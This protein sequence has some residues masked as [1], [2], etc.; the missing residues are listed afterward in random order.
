MKPAALHMLAMAGS[1]LALS[2]AT[3]TSTD[4]QSVA[5]TGQLRT[6]MTMDQV[7]TILGKPGLS[8]SLGGYTL[9]QY[10][11]P[12]VEVS[13]IPYYVTFESKT[14]TL[15]GWYMNTESYAINQT[16]WRR[17]PPRQEVIPI[18]HQKTVD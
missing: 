17:S 3:T 11:F 15:I 7:V 1:L 14:N 6:G 18:S 8:E 5:Q 10:S 9:W 4:V 12:V 16:G 2:C 13:L